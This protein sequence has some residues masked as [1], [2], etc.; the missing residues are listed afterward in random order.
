MKRQGCHP[1]KHCKWSHKTKILKYGKKINISANR[2]SVNHITQSALGSVWLSDFCNWWISIQDYGY[3]SFS[4]EITQLNF[5]F[6]NEF[7]NTKTSEPM[8]GL[9]WKM[10]TRFLKISFSGKWM[11]FSFLEASCTPS[12]VTMFTKGAC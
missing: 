4:L 11:R 12:S 3:C 9:P 10:Y 7:E 6:Y 2:Q 1:I 8:T 5:F